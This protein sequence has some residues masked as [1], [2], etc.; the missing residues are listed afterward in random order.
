[1]ENITLDE[2]I[3]EL[4]PKKIYKTEKKIFKNVKIDSRMVEEGDLFIALIGKN[5][6]AHNFLDEVFKKGAY[7]AIVQKAVEY[8]SIVVDNT[9]EALKTIAGLV[10]NKSKAQSIAVTGSSGKTTTKE[11][12]C[13]ILNKKSCC[14]TEGNENNFIG[15]SK[16][17]LKSDTGGICVVEVGTNHKGE[18]SEIA[19]F[20][21]PDIVVF[22]NIGQSHLGNFGSTDNILREK[23]SILTDKKQKIVYNFDDLN[24]RSIF[25][26][27]GISCSLIN[28]NADVFIEKINDDTI[29]LSFKNK[30]IE[31]EKPKDINIYNILLAVA[32]SKTLDENIS[33]KEI[34]KGLKNVQIP[35]LRMQ[36]EEIGKT[37]FILDCYNANPNSMRY[38]ISVLAQKPGK[39]LAV[40]GDMLE[41]GEFSSKIH[42]DMG[43]FISAFDMDLIAYGNESYNIYKTAQKSL[44][45]AKFFD[46]KEKLVDFLKNSYKDYDTILI[47]GSR[48]MEME[49]IF[50]RLKGDL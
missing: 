22:T 47:K 13:S 10:F 46:K 31:I 44:K 40:L 50:Y 3:K 23:I 25:E 14:K 42:E 19:E 5:Y 20:F 39:K 1:M 4:K 29:I 24:L 34:D 8:P 6:D 43:K 12:I 28:P 36:N 37:V 21:K 9:F 30:K 11:L 45:N 26:N 33:E 15:V 2:L 18:M 32:A 49:T 27:K 41:L 17:L 48:A 38:A 7:A 16:T 35:H